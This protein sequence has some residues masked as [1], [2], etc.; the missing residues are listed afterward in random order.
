MSLN[1]AG[2]FYMVAQLDADKVEPFWQEFTRDLAA[3]DAGKITPDVIERARFNYEDGMDRASETLDGLTSWKA[4]VQF[5]LGG[6]QGE[7]NV[8]PRESILLPRR[9]FLSRQSDFPILFSG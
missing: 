2:L 7:A 3:L 1:R 6:P 4:T 9:N 5:E 8:P